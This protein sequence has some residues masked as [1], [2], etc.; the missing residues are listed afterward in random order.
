MSKFRF[1]LATL[2]RLRETAR[3]ECRSQLAEALRAADVV[4]RRLAEVAEELALLSQHVRQALAPGAVPVDRLLDAQRY[5]VLLRLQQKTM[6]DEQ[7]AIEREI[8]R[9]RELLAAADREVRTL[10]RLRESQ[11][12][13]HRAEL[14]RQALAQMDEA[15]A[16]CT[17]QLAEEVER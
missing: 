6:R 4:E 7:T 8:E 14:E 13:R 10:E 16:R 17:P 15:A 12:E 5:E 1:R 9:R 3:D 2:L 11:S